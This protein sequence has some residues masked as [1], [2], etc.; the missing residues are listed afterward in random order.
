VRG[1]RGA[2]VVLVALGLGAGGVAIWF[3]LLTGKPP[4]VREALG[5]LPPDTETVTFAAGAI[6][7]EGNRQPGDLEAFARSLPLFCGGAAKPISSLIASRELLFAVEGS[8]NFRAPNG[9]GLGPFD[10]ASVLVLPEERSWSFHAADFAGQHG[11]ST[12]WIA[13]SLAAVIQEKLESNT[14]SF[15]L[16][17]PRPGVL[18]IA[19]E[20]GY[21]AELLGRIP[22]LR[23]T[24]ALDPFFEGC[25]ARTG[26]ARYWAI[27]RYDPGRA[28]LDPTS[29]LKAN[30]DA[31]NAPDLQ[32]RGLIFS[33]DPAISSTARVLYLSANQSAEQIAGGYWRHPRES[34]DPVIR[35][36][37]PGAVEILLEAG[38]T[39]GPMFCFI[40]FAALG[41]VVFI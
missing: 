1:R 15:F 26:E 37:S 39:G 3:H 10:G 4:T 25:L 13:G 27:R 21:L 40:L 18:I 23:R 9:L 8:R 32:A 35:T 6:L 29:P 33:Y 11:G 22:L 24:R 38:S 17:S 7:D 41:H 36:A 28:M 30:R 20:E 2:I 19:T 14:W 12:R 34:L 31:A 5:W 16:V